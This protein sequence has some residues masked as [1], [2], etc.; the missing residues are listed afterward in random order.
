LSNQSHPIFALSAAI[1]DEVAAMSPTD[2]TYAGI[3]GHDDRWPDLSPGGH[4]NMLA[5][6]RAMIDR[7]DALPASESK[8]DRLAMAAARSFA[9]QE[10]DFYDHGDHLLDLDSMASPA[11]TIVDIFDHMDQAS[12]QGWKNI[13]SRLENMAEVLAGFKATLAAGIA[14]GTTVARRQVEAV[15]AQSRVAASDESGFVALIKEFAA[16]GT[17]PVELDA[18]LRTAV[19][20]A[21]AAQ[22]EF[23]QWLERHYLPHAVNRDA[24]GEKR[25]VRSARKFLGT[26]IDPGATYEWGWTEV[27]R[28]RSR[29]E[30]VAEEISSGATIAEALHILKTDP[31]RAAATREDFISFMEQRNAIALAQLDGTHFEVPDSIREVQVKLASPGGPLGAYYVGP[32]EDFSRPG[33]VWWSHGTNQGPFPLYDEVSTLY[34]EGFPGHHLQVGVQVTRAENLSRLHRMLVWLPGL[35]EGWALYAERMM[36]QLGFL[37]KPDYVFGFLA[38]QM[39]RACRVV[40]D[41]GSHLEL[42]IP[43]GQPFHPGENW[44]F[45]LGVEMLQEYA[46]LEKPYAESEMTRYLGWPGQAISYKVGEKAIL[47]IRATLESRGG[48]AAKQFHADL[49]EIG[50]VGLDLVRELLVG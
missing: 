2:A 37:D 46:T 11:Q 17:Y 16:P 47:D 18:R 20:A 27:A 8:W 40:I 30:E 35:G 3:T 5:K 21:R 4:A 48:F 49:L 14:A 24:V 45:E 34:H 10:V 29:M 19:A 1:V 36:D 39:L 38:A 28:L 42:T 32:S 25:Y 12:E 9:Q 31:N 50:P 7:I 44:D 33:A 22:A 6:Y 13:C 43:D 15:A 23:G 26:D 41:I